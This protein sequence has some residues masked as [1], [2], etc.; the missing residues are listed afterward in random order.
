MVIQIYV[1]DNCITVEAQIYCAKAIYISPASRD[2]LLCQPAHEFTDNGVRSVGGHSRWNPM[3]NVY[4]TP[5][6]E[7]LVQW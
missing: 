6:A 5:R 7:G 4:I 2:V 1:A 3:Y